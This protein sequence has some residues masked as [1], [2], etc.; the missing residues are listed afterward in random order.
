M[1]VQVRKRTV[2]EKGAGE[3]ATSSASGGVEK[4]GKILRTET[5]LSY[6]KDLEF[7]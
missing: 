3:G 6:L 2:A 7:F 1:Q 5:L 4:K